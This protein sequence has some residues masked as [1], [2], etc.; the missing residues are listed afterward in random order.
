MASEDFHKIS[1]DNIAFVDDNI[2]K[3]LDDENSHRSC[4]ILVFVCYHCM[5]YIPV[6]VEYHLAQYLLDLTE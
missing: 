2:L 4:T 1:P 6:E 5:L 3:K